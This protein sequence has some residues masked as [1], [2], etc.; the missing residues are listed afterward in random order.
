L[1]LGL[2]DLAKPFLFRMDPE[3][4]HALSMSFMRLLPSVNLNDDGDDEKEGGGGRGLLRVKT[5][6]GVLRNPIGLAAGFDKTGDHLSVLQRLGFGYL[7]AGTVMLD[8]FPGNP[9]PRVIR[10]PGEKTILNCLGF[11]NPGVERFVQ[12]IS[13]QKQQELRV[14]VVGS[15]SGR[16]IESVVECYEKIQQEQPLIAGVEVNLSS[17][18]TAQLKDLREPGP[19]VELARRLKE[20][21]RKPTFLKVPPLS[22]GED[23]GGDGMMGTSQFEEKTMRLVRLWEDLGFEGVT[24]AN[25]QTKKDP[26]LSLGVGGYSGPPIY[27]NMIKALK[28]V[29]KKVSKDFEINA[30]G[31]VSSAKDVEEA[32]REGANTVQIFTAIVFEGPGLVKRILEDLKDRNAV[33]GLEPISV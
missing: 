31:G 11:P 21:K 25:S 3:R 22:E 7:V 30:V 33:R 29:R 9:K 26:R 8:P 2:Y 1:A 13:K 16:T 24:V 23:F 12:N 32:L 10:N 17:P 20:A 28:I 4:A 15:V 19:F 18:N 5:S 6:L 14:P 27:Q